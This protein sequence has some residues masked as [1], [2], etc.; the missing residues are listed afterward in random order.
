MSSD[1]QARLRRKSLLGQEVAHAERLLSRAGRTLSGRSGPQLFPEQG[2]AN[3]GAVCSE[4]RAG[5][6]R[7][8]FPEKELRMPSETDRGP[9]GQGRACQSAMVCGAWR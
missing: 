4:I 1:I 6:I 7:K 5:A 8:F 2:L 3:T 9:G